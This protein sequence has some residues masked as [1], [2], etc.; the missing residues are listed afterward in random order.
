MLGSMLTPKGR[1]CLSFTTDV[2][3]DNDIRNYRNYNFDHLD[4]KVCDMYKYKKNYKTMLT[5]N[6]YN[7]SN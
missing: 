7:D 2:I 1:I 6:I 5:A 4:K 3:V